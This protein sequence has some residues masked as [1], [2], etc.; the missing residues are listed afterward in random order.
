MDEVYELEDNLAIWHMAAGFLPT[1][2]YELEV[3]GNNTNLVLK[4][5]E[6]D[7]GYLSVGAHSTPITR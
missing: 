4:V 2:F 7:V 3:E 5:K 1:I 6:A